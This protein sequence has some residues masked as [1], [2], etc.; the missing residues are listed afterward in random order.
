MRLR[1]ILA[2]LLGG[3]V[4]AAALVAS[5]HLQI[6]PLADLMK[7]TEQPS[8]EP[9]VMPPPAVTV[10]SV[11]S[12]ELVET[13]LV[14]GTLVPRE[15]IL[16]A[17]EVEGLRVL[18]LSVDV[19]DT[20]KRGDVLAT[21]VRETLDAQLAQNDAALARV[22]AQTEQAKSEIAAAE[23]RLEEA[24]AQYE[25]A[26][27]LQKSGYLSDSTFDQRRAT[28]RTTE[29]QLA[30]ARDGLK[31]AEAERAQLDAQRRELVWRLSKS[32]V[33]A[34][35]DGLISRRNARIGGLATG[36][37]D[38]MFRII[39]DGEIELDAELTEASLAKVRVGQPAMVAVAGSEGIAGKVR[40]VSPEVDRATR[41]G[42]VRVFLGT[43]PELRI[44]GFAR[45]TIT[46]ARSTGLAVPVS[47]VMYDSGGPTVQVVTDGKVN[48][49]RISAGLVANGLIEIRSGLTAGEMVV[50]RSGTFLREGDSVK[51]VLPS[52]KVSE[53]GR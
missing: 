4:G 15:E 8:A 12:T 41:L 40:L 38:P 19:G 45:G 5:G 20:V 30:A 33:R 25:R 22:A 10:V 49:R 46:T 37:G 23:A 24:K 17:P 13:V 21:L 39:R 28:A 18:E 3:T 51:P 42:R 29:A 52:A 26:K 44:G 36:L 50:A 2:V 9:S 14:T 16:V 27:P 11:E 32:E 47:A 7:S 31:L 35:T 1:T 48:V 53:A 6:G 43:N 34:P